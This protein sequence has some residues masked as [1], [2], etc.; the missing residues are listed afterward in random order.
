MEQING[1]TA[2][3]VDL[4]KEFEI[5]FFSKIAKKRYKGRFTTKKLSIMD[6]TRVSVRQL[7]MN[8]GYHYDSD[9]PGTGLTHEMSV[10]SNIIA[11]LEIALIQTP[12]WW[13]LE[14]LNDYDL[15]SEVY[16]HVANFEMGVESPLQK[17]AVDNRSGEEDS[18]EESKGSG[19]A[20]RAEEVGGGEV[21]ASL[22]P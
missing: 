14:I 9:K 16:G 2:V 19:A 21:P 11:H 18:G 7:N 15:L 8:G 13:N 3:P 12:D 6:L 5:D 4:R 20:G 22:D 10:T 1:A 17:A